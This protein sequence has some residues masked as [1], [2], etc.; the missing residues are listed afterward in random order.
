M[1]CIFLPNEISL[2]LK[3]LRGTAASDNYEEKGK[4][5]LWNKSFKTFAKLKEDNSDLKKQWKNEN[6]LNTTN[7][8]TLSLNISAYKNP[9]ASNLFSIKNIEGLKKEKFG[10]IKTSKQS[11]NGHFK[12]QNPFEFSR[13]QDGDQKNESEVMQFSASKRLL[14][15]QPP[16]TNN[17]T[18]VKEMDSCDTLANVDMNFK[19]MR[20]CDGPC[21]G[22]I[23]NDQLE[24]FECCHAICGE[25]LNESTA[26]GMCL[27]YFRGLLLS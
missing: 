25:C 5:Q 21:K 18:L 7:K 3:V 11:F 27:T 14:D 12:S 17:K 23:D 8:S 9:I 26:I 13:Q 2:Y 15:S 1:T 20:T 10:S 24:Y 16:K 6:T 4:L 22:L 19:D